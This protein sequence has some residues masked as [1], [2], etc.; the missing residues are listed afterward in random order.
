MI[1][2]LLSFQLLSFFSLYG[3]LFSIVS[4][5][6]FQ[7]KVPYTVEKV[8]DRQ[9]PY[10]GT[11]ALLFF[12]FCPAF[13]R[14]CLLIVLFLDLSLLFISLS[15]LAFSF[16]LSF[17][18]SLSRSGED[19]PAHDHP[20]RHPPGHPGGAGPRPR[21][22]SF[23]LLFTAVAPLSFW[24]SSLPFTSFTL[25]SLFCLLPSRRSLAASSFVVTVPL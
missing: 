15:F 24:P 19:L 5:G 4:F 9:V 25:T 17:S 7:V 21:S 20:E 13:I 10:P 16:L 2:F 6:P 12:R 3:G 18:V 8:V 22:L 1:V 14:F 23:A 11:P